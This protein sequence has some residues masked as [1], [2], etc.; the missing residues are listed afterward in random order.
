MSSSENQLRYE[1]EKLSNILSKMQGALKPLF[2]EKL[3]DSEVP[4]ITM[5]TTDIKYV[6]Y[7]IEKGDLVKAKEV[8]R[9]LKAVAKNINSQII[10]IE[11]II[12]G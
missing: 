10:D 5:S 12:E 7:L 11:K 9:S 4:K 2:T 6:E 1:L 8:L 3:T